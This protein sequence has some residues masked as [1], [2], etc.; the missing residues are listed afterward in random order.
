M[1]I[2]IKEVEIIGDKGKGKAK[3]LF[4]SGATNSLI[5]RDIAEKISSLTKWSEPVDFT[6]GDGKTV[7]KSEFYTALQININGNK[8]PGQ[9]FHVVENI[10]EELILG[11]DA[12][13]RWK[14]K[15]DFEKE[16][17]II[18]KNVLRL[19]LV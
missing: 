11:A 16:D 3:I 2:I 15:L 9:L 4:D 17:V 6:L 7:V 14:F 12:F 8:I 13:Q 5:R 1:G 10:E 19:R 18:D